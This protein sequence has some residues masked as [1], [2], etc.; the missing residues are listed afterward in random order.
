M[1]PGAS[2]GGL[3]ILAERGARPP[4]GAP[5]VPSSRRASSYTDR[6]HVLEEQLRLRDVALNSTNTYFLIVA[7]GTGG[8][9]IV[10][11]NRAICVDHGYTPEELLGQSPA[12]LTPLELN[13]GVDRSIREA[14]ASGTSIRLQLQARRKKDGSVFDTG[15][16]ITPIRDSSGTKQYSVSVGG[17]YHGGAH[18]ARS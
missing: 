3:A 5:R 6:A 8:P 2:R 14:I 4:A 9:E 13:P 12:L 1:L 10:Y 15:V 18:R 7:S 16:T 17:E 11:V